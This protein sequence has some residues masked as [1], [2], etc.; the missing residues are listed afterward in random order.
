[1]ELK[2]LDQQ[3]WLRLLLALGIIWGF[4]PLIMLPFFF[5]GGNDTS[6]TV[7]A[8]IFNALTI[9]P[10]C[11]LALWHR[12]PACIW[13]TLNGS[14]LAI[15]FAQKLRELEPGTIAFLIGAMLIAICLDFMEIRHWPGALNR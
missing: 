11:V 5:R 13:L 3:L 10:A 6:L 9:L 12:R 8:G 7:F 14:L 15:A 1:M 2:S 4:I